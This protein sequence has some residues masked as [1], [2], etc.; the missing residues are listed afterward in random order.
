M[1][2]E[3]IPTAVA[4]FEKRVTSAHAR[5][6]APDLQRRARRT[7]GSV[8]KQGRKGAVVRDECARVAAQGLFLEQGPV[9]QNIPG[10]AVSRAAAGAP[11]FPVVGHMPGGVV[12]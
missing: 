8:A 1:A 6:A 10:Q 11:E 2:R 3:S 4:G 12:E 9:R 7:A 5:A